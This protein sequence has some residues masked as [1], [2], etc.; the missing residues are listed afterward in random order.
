MVF[1]TSCWA[2]HDKA[3]QKC[4]FDNALH[5][6]ERFPIGLVFVS[7]SVIVSCF[8]HM[9]RGFRAIRRAGQA[10]Q[11]ENIVG[12]RT[13]DKHP[14]SCRIH[15]KHLSIHGQEPVAGALALTHAHADAC[16]HTNSLT[17]TI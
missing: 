16:D 17:Q 15:T 10:V 6:N 13:H 4:S 8:L 11:V 14:T 12:L 5:S 9:L 1:V 7:N 2:T 3:F